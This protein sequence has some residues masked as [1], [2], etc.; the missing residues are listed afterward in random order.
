ML[1][2]MAK[3]RRP[4]KND[5]RLVFEFDGVPWVGV[6]EENVVEIKHR[7]YREQQIESALSKKLA[8]QLA[9]VAATQ[10]IRI[11][12]AIPDRAKL[13]VPDKADLA[14][15]LRAVTLGD[16]HSLIE[17]GAASLSLTGESLIDINVESRSEDVQIAIGNSMNQL[18]LLGKSYL[19]SVI[20][21]AVASGAWD[22]GLVTEARK[23]GDTLKV[24][25]DGKT[26]TVK[27][28]RPDFF[29]SLIAEARK[30]FMPKVQARPRFDPEIKLAC[31]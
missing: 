26:T 7:Q 15:R 18:I 9:S 25:G 8:V 13:P 24:S 5:K 30:A 17:S 6:I 2:M 23:W 4:K 27:I 12:L 29:A 1:K 20:Q 3:A 28:S 21:Y 10:D 11:A 31:Y 14:T 16:L 19:Q 22:Q